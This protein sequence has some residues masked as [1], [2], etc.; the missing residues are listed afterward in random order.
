MIILGLTGSIGMGKTETA[1]MF[2][3]CGLPVYDADG[4][5]H[6]IY[7]AGGAAVAPV[8]EAFPG[9][10]VDGAVDRRKLSKLVLG[11]DGAG[12]LAR[13]EAIAH[14][15]V[16]ELQAQF[17]ETARAGG[18]GLVVLDIPLLLETGADSACDY[19]AVVS[20]PQKTQR[21]RVLAR[22]GMSKERLEAVLS[23]QMPDPEKRDRADFVIK[24]GDGFEA[25]E[26]RVREIV[27]QLR[28]RTGQGKDQA[29]KA[30]QGA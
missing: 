10:V 12:A 22:P 11:E 7:S 14:P 3:D 30:E 2:R 1:R 4:A 28:A 23:R 27:E 8:G 16:R 25:A 5:V 17:L 26:A 6:E 15:L 9:V 29:A 18:H 24:T 19:V 20:A 21:Q 13:L